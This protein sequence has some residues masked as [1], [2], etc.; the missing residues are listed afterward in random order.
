MILRTCDGAA[1]F[2]FRLLVDSPGVAHAVFTRRFGHSPPPYQGLNVGYGTG[3]DRENVAANRRVIARCM[4]A[5]RLVFSHQVHGT[6]VLVVERE[7]LYGSQTA[8]TVGDAMVTALPG[9]HLAIQVADCQAVMLY[10][11]TRRVVANIHV[12]WRGS[13]DGIIGKTIDVMEQRFGCRPDH[14]KAGIGP[15]LG[16][17]CAEFVNYKKEIPRRFWPYMDKRRRFDFWAISRDQLLAAGLLPEN[18]AVSRMCTRCRPD[19]FFS[20]RGEK[21]TGRFAAVIG[22]KP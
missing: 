12:G 9:V 18:I 19:L 17:C 20:Y 8:G 14:I 13:I 10:D 2:Q 1:F 7:T 3:D 16:P 22:L 4:A 6:R 15:S 11:E 21:T 5:D